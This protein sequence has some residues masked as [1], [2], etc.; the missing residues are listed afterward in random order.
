MNRLAAGTCVQVLKFLVDDV[1]INAI[2]RIT[3][4]AKNTVLKLLA[5]VGKACAEFLDKNVCNLKCKKI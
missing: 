2:C 5:E 1:G 4:V 3:R